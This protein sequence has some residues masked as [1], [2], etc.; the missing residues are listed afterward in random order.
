M[1]WLE[2][3]DITLLQKLI[4]EST[5]GDHGIRSQEL[6]ESAYFAPMASY[7]SVELFPETIQKIGRLS[8]GLTVNHP[9][10]DGNKRVGALVLLVLLEQNGYKIELEPLMLSSVYYQI[11]ASELGYD[12]FMDWLLQKDAPVSE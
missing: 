4:V 9:F 8:W 12:E 5:G 10:I 7:A 11:A 3:D 2:Q 6:L 1:N